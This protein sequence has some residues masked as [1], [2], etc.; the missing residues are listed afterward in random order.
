M[1]EPFGAPDWATRDQPLSFQW[2]G[3]S[4]EQLVSAGLPLVGKKNR[5]TARRAIVANLI[6]AHCGGQWVSYSRDR[7]HYTGQARYQ[8]EAYTYVN[9]LNVVEEF[10]AARLICE[11]RA[12]RG[13]LGWQSRMTASPELL[14]RIGPIRGLQYSPRELVRLKDA[15]GVLIDYRDTAHTRKM[16]CEVAELNEALRSASISLA[17][18]DVK[19]GGIAVAL[20]GQIVHPSRIAGYRVFNNSWE[21]GGRFYGPFWQSLPKVRRADLTIGG[22]SVREHDFAQLHPR[23]LYA[24]F[25]SSPEND[26]YSIDGYEDQ[27]ETV[28][29]AWQIMINA[30][31]R[32][33]AVAAL[34]DQLGGF[35]QQY[36][37]ARLLEA[38]EKRHSMISEAFY[39][40]A[41][42]RL[43]RTDSELMLHIERR[44]LSEGIIA[45]PVHD[46]FIVKTA[47]SERVHEIMEEELRSTLNAVRSTRT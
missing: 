43:Q 25:G 14:L 5:C 32:R 1:T 13:Q 21:R 17:S 19:W 31:S 28:K 47:F 16:R 27:R 46:S 40:G 11:E 4:D 26:A 45:L 29:C 18:P 6:R 36:K 10:N 15:E 9:V 30:L 23:L 37:A 38:L 44:C 2:S 8:G 35:H 7:N 39:T 41:G 34:A 3:I 12:R 33:S 42:L 22:M 24:E 20:D